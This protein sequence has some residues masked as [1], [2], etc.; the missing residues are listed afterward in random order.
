[1]SLRTPVSRPLVVN[2]SISSLSKYF[3]LA[4]SWRN[5]DGMYRASLSLS[6]SS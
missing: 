3:D 2:P 1:M 6:N 5:S 4:L